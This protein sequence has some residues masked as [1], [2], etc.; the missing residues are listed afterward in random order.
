MWLISRANQGYYVEARRQF[1]NGFYNGFYNGCKRMDV[2]ERFLRLSP[3]SHL[4][5]SPSPHLPISLSPHFSLSHSRTLPLSL[6]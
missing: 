2:Q 1:G 5:I 4:P 6:Q 3:S